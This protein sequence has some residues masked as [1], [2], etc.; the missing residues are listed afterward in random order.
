M[1][2][3]VRVVH[4]HGWQVEV[5][6]DMGAFEPVTCASREDALKLAEG[7]APDWIEVGDVI[8]LDTPDK[9]HAWTT[10]RRRADGSYGSSPL[11]WQ[12]GK[13]GR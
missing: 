4:R 3:F 1:T 2:T 10:L 13:P 9:R 8:G 6:P 12:T 7:L 11:R 5:V